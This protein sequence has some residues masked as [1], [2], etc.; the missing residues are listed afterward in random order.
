MYMCC[1]LNYYNF[2]RHFFDS[3]IFS[4]EITCKNSIFNSFA[5]WNL[6]SA[7]LDDFFVVAL[8]L[9]Y[10]LSSFYYCLWIFLSFP[11]EILKILFYV[12]MIHRLLAPILIE[13]WKYF[14]LCTK[15]EF[16]NERVRKT[17]H[18]YSLCFIC[19]WKIVFWTRI[20]IC[21]SVLKAVF[22]KLIS[23]FTLFLHRN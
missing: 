12:M 19:I 9:W 17:M 11:C 3:I 5:C 6:S 20:R 23:T 7:L 18:I 1:A 14:R 16:L 8:Y 21:I 10:H 2:R 15:D 13:N 22:H 4:I